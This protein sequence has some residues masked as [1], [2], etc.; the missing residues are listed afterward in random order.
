LP[1]SKAPENLKSEAYWTYASTTKDKGN[2]ADG[3]FSADC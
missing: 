2:A 1:R 3:H